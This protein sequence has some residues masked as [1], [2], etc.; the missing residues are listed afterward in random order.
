MRFSLDVLPAREGDCL[1]L[2]FGSE[3]KPGLIMIDGGP[4]GVY[5]PHLKPRI[6]RVRA[7]RGL[8]DQDT[9]PV[10]AVVVSHVDD[11]HITGI[12]ELTKELRAQKQDQQPLLLRAGSLWH[13]SF[14][15]LLD[16]TPQELTAAAGFGAAALAGDAGSGGGGDFDLAKVLASIPQ[17]RALRDDAEYLKWK[18]NDK[19][20]GSL[21]LATKG[22][23][24]VKLAGG[25]TVTV[26]GPL[27]PELLAL[28][29]QHDEWLRAQAKKKKVSPE[30]ALAAFVDQS[31]TNLS[32][33]V[34]LVACGAKRMLLTGDARGDKV[35]EGL[36][37][38][39]L[40]APGAGSVVHVDVLKVPHH[41]SA[42]NVETAFFRRVTADHYVFSGNGGYGNP[43]RATLEMLFQARGSAPLTLHF[44][45]PVADIDR[46]RRKDWEQQQGKEK[47][48][49]AL[50]P[51]KK[52]KVRENWSDAKHSLAAFFQARP[53]AGGQRIQIVPDGTPHVIDLLDPVGF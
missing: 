10:D 46:E 22:T 38:A 9:L 12:L 33:I 23:K 17:G 28:Q 16:T 40:L 47:K 44:T 25:L 42:N 1:M 6:E 39:G 53:L 21:I 27:K 51:A 49:A 43:E 45:Y 8:E 15:D 29:K 48:A 37:L 36:A 5:R 30:S 14:D 13:N 20:K 34:L 50:D 7:A 2:H 4:P 19:F 35:M 52:S 24:P 41:G 31:V 3:S 32:S 18:R 11:D 26:L